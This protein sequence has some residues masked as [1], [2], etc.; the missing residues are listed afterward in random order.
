ME[1]A[2]TVLIYASS[3]LISM[4]GLKVFFNLFKD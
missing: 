3:F 4:L 1:N 2:L